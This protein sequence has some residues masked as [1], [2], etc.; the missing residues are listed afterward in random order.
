MLCVSQMSVHLKGGAGM[1]MIQNYAKQKLNAGQLTIGFGIRQARTV[2]IAKIAK[3][4]GFDWLFIDMEHS[5]MEVDVV[6]QICV[7]ALDAGVTPLVRVPGHEP[8]HISRVLDGGAMGVVVPHVNTVDQARG[9]V[10]TCKYPPAGHRSIASALPQLEYEPILSQETLD[11]LNENLLVVAMLETPRA[12]ENAEAIAAVDGI[13]VLHIGTNDLLAEMGI[14]GQFGHDRVAAAYQTTI[15]ATQKYGKFTGI[16]GI[17]DDDLVRRFVQ[18]G[19]RFLTGALEAN[20]LIQAARKRAE[21]L[22][23]IPLTAD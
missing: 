6:S 17:S 13:D 1:G 5:T 2:D 18:M 21:V 23:S 12:I 3:T 4:C 20:L 15:A 16:G 11:L 8:F 9:I 10:D 7:A 14:P 19:A 22:R